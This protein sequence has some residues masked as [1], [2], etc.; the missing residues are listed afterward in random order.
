MYNEEVLER[1][2]NYYQ[3]DLYI[4]DNKIALNYLFN[5]GLYPET[6][7]YF[8]LGYTE[9]DI[10]LNKFSKYITIPIIEH[11][12]VKSFTSRSLNNEAPIHKHL[13]QIPCP[14]NY[15]EN[16]YIIITES[17]IDT[18]ILF[19]EGFSAISLYG[20]NGYKT[21]YINYLKNYGRVYILF[22]NDIKRVMDKNKTPGL[23]ASF[24][25]ALN[26]YK[27]TGINALIGILPEI[28]NLNKVDINILFLY[29]RNGFRNIV[30]K[31]LDE[32]IPY[33]KTKHYQDYL[34]SLEIKQNKYYIKSYKDDMVKNIKAI[35]LIKALE[36][37]INLKETNFGAI[38]ECPFHSDT[39]PSFVIYNNTNMWLCM[40][41]CDD[42][43]DLIKFYQ[44][45]YNLSFIDAINKIKK[46]MAL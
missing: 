1:A 36:G 22:D 18:M 2:C 13:G 4:E 44:K 20:T 5:R 25:S 39:N 23:T 6:I 41:A 33:I 3:N 37:I 21:K 15:K 27:D 19:Q 17:P 42:K 26:I 24:K 32:S 34:K 30:R 28:E 46:E 9:N 14:F 16:E 10:I 7:K 31:V 8:R 38:S 40:G 11:K 12:N 35:P 43:G 29:N 45:Y